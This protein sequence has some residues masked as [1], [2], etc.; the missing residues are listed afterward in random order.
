M[1]SIASA[2]R[3]A[4]VPKV[5]LSSSRRAAGVKLP[6]ASD[7]FGVIV[8]GAMVPFFPSAGILTER[9]VRMDGLN[10]SALARKLFDAELASL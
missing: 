1:R 5:V 3:L 6:A 9:A 4:A 10:I 2:L 8:G 7:R